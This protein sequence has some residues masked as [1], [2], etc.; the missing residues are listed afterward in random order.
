MKPKRYLLQFWSLEREKV[1][2]NQSAVLKDGRQIKLKIW[3]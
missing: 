1:E 2:E 3:K